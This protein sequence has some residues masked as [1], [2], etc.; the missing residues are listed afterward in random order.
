MQVRVALVAVAEARAERRV[1]RV[2]TG[3]TAVE[4]KDARVAVVV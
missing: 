1:G 4:G 2:K 3:G